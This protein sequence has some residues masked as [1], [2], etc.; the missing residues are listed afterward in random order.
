MKES[1]THFPITAEWTNLLAFDLRFKHI[2]L[3]IC[4]IYCLLAITETST[5][6]ARTTCAKE[7]AKGRQTEGID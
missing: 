6:F 4:K 5:Y 3:F 7:L 1:R 2:L